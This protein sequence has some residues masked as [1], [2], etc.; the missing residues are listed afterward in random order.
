M[1]ILNHLATG[2]A[3]A[4]VVDKPA[5]ALPVAL[6]SHFVLDV[7]PH[8]GYPGE[9]GYKEAFRHRLSYLSLVFDAIGIAVLFTLVKDSIWVVFASAFL[10]I[11]PDAVWPY[12]YFMFE[13]KNLALPDSRYARFHAGIQWCE[14]E[15]GIIIEVIY[16]IALLLFIRGHV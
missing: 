16:S 6:V 14:R 2:A 13:R 11:V 15:W 3:I 4:L 7:V 5:I 10:A 1:N 12:R 8:Y 9:E